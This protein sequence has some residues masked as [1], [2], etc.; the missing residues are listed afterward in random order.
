VSR[1]FPTR[2]AFLLLAA[3]PGLLLACGGEADEEATPEGAAVELDMEGEVVEPPFAVRGEADRLLLA[4]FD[5]EGLHSAASREDVPEERRE[6]VRVESLT[7]APEDRLDPE[8]VYVADLR[9]AGEHGGYVVRK[10]QRAAFDALVDRATGHDQPVAQAQA[11]AFAGVHGDPNADIII[12]GASWCG[13]C[14]SAAAF[15]RQR[16]VPFQEKDIER[17]PGA[18]AEMQRKAQEAGVRPSGIPVI[19]FRGRILTG[20]DQA[21]MQRLLDQQARP[22]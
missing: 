2:P 10:L 4:W 1:P 17:D 21:T 15:L 6:R 8:F 13:A 19:D 9:Q 5:E 12:Y 14:R 18:R 22:I 3:L 7:I 16:G 11:Q 20:F